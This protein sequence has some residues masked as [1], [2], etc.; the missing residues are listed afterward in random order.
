MG[1]VAGKDVLALIFY[2]GQWRNYA[3]GL[4][5]SMDVSTDFIETSTRGNGKSKT[6]IPTTDEWTATLEGVMTLQ[7]SGLLSLPDFRDIQDAQI[8]LLLRSQHTDDVGNVYTEEGTAYISRTTDTGAS[9]GAATFTIELR[10]TGARTRIYTTTATSS[11][12]VMRLEYTAAGGEDS[13]TDA[14]LVGKMAIAIFRDGI[15][16]SKLLLTGT[17]INKEV[18]FNS[19][20]GTLTFDAGNHLATGEEIAVLYQ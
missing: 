8:P 15:E 5:I 7:Q 11:L 2:N 16:Q 17:P 4:S 18:L 6:F 9:E 19:V 12:P 13:F 14:L 20:T 1:K 10:G 3:C